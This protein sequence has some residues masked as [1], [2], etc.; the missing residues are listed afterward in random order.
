VKKDRFKRINL[1]CQDESRFG[2]HTFTGKMLTAKGVKPIAVSQQ[3]FESTWLFGAFSPINGKR[4][5]MEAEECNG[6]FFQVFPDELSATDTDELM[7]ILLDNASFHKHK[8]LII[9]NNIALIYIPPY[10]PELNLAEKIW[11][12]FK[13]AFTNRPF[14]TMEEIHD[15]LTVQTNLLSEDIVISTC[16]YGWIASCYHWTVL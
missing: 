9:P 12:R 11:Q 15:F 10:S 2:L 14:K 6:I 5:L 3:A 4:M 8:K 7:L 1:Y 16:A 13:R